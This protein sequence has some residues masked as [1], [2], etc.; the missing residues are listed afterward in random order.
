M[1]WLNF[2][3]LRY[4][5][6]VAREGSVSKAAKRLRVTQPTISGQL[7]ELQDSLGEPLFRRAGRQLALTDLGR[8]V[9]EIA[10]EIFTLGDQIL[11]RVKGK[12]TGRPQR[13]SVGISDSVPKRVAYR[14]LEPAIAARV[15]IAC[16]E[17]PPARLVADL[18]AQALDVVIGDAPSHEPRAH[19][20]LL[21]ESRISV[22]GVRRLATEMRVGF[23]RSLDGAPFLLPSANTGF[24]REL[25]AWFV[26]HGIR[27]RIVGEFEDAALL[28]EFAE[29]GAG[30]YATPD[31][32]V[33]ADKPRGLLRAGGIKPL[34]AR[35]Y[36]ITVER[37]LA[38]PAVA[39]VAGAEKL[40]GRRRG[41]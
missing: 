4:F 11:D 37:R 20:H 36:A 10:N 31:V 13:L 6:V 12:A 18:A 21:G 17:G 1:D 5:W 39:L 2:H 40:F 29:A 26:E 34:R 24:R 7:R 14:I 8:S 35:Y 22:W 23:P 33:E 27:P 15:Q 16:H 32:V 25:D 9:L 3:H 19:D 30:L 41:T 38:H 28:A